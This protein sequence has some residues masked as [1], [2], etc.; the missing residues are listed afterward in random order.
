MWELSALLWGAEIPAS[1]VPSKSRWGPRAYGEDLS[2][3]L[4]VG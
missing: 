2:R 4:D 1:P 3:R